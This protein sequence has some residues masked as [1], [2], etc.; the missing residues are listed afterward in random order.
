MKIAPIFW[1]LLL[2]SAVVHGQSNEAPVTLNITEPENGTVYSRNVRFRAALSTPA[3]REYDVKVRCFEMTHWLLCTPT[4][5]FSPKIS[6]KGRVKWALWDDHFLPQSGDQVM[7]IE[8]YELRNGVPVDPD[9]PVARAEVPF[10]FV[11]ATKEELAEDL[12]GQSRYIC[13]EGISLALD[14]MEPRSPYRA[15][16]KLRGKEGVMSSEALSYVTRRHY[17][18]WDRTNGYGGAAYHLDRAGHPGDALRALRMAEEIYNLEKNVLLSGPGFQNWPIVWMNTY[19]S[20]P[21]SFFGEYADFYA[22]RNELEKAIH[23]QK[24]RAGFYL[25][26]AS[27]HPL[28][29]PIRREKCHKEAARCYQRIGRLHYLLKRDRAEWDAWMRKYEQALPVS[30]RRS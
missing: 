4:G 23:W 1:S 27:G 30:K 29:E 18:F 26:Q 28:F 5:P 11:P 16:Q 14:F 15:L 25:R 13:A 7:E 10:R 21:P 9:T 12:T 17:E 8:V 22:R 20:D 2:L 24:E 3:G 19:S 6:P